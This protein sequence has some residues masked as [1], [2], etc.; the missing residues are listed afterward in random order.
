MKEV[1]EGL[2]GGPGTMVQVYQLDW[3]YPVWKLR[4]DTKTGLVAVECRDADTLQTAFSIFN[5]N[6]GEVVLRD[7]Q[8][9]NAWWTGLA[10]IRAGLLYLQGVAAKGIGRPAGITAISIESG[11]VKWQRPEFS[12]YSLTATEILVL[13][14]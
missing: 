3:D 2:S 8:P 12:F 10:E 7:L 11:Q 14:A 5:A 9:A 4:C 13:P 6:T 1:G